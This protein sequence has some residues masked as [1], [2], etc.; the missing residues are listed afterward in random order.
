MIA[1]TTSPFFPKFFRTKN[2][3]KNLTFIQLLN[4]LNSLFIEIF[5]KKESG[6]ISP[7]FTLKNHFVSSEQQ[8]PNS[9]NLLI[10]KKKEYNM[11]APTSSSPL[12]EIAIQLP[13]TPQ[14]DLDS[15]VIVDVGTFVSSKDMDRYLAC[16]KQN[17]GAVSVHHLETF[18]HDFRPCQKIK[19][20]GH[21]GCVTAGRLKM[22]LS[23]WEIMWEDDFIGSIYSI[24]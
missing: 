12:D 9:N 8:F 11:S 18:E 15:F 1:P 24:D 21:A 5:R 3:Q 4:R 13:H 6:Q 10:F 16:I 19:V 22:R 14:L 17:L 20:V 2:I 23:G 7:Q